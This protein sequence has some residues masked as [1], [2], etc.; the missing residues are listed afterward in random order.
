MERDLKI[1]DNKYI[2]KGIISQTKNSKIYFGYSINS[3]SEKL[4]IKAFKSQ[5]FSK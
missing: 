3:P 2:I 5:N 4:I 1:L